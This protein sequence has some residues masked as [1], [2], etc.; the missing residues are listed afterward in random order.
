[1]ALNPALRGVKSLWDAGRLAIVRGV[2][3]PEPS[4]SH[5]RSMAV[6]QSADPVGASGPGWI[7]RWLDLTGSGA[8]RAV[9]I[10]AVLPPVLRGDK[11]AAASITAATVTLPG[12][13]MLQGGYAALTA[14]GPDRAG[15]A[16]QVTAAGADLLGVKADLDRLAGRPG[17]PAGPG[18][19]SLS[20]Q[21]QVVSSLIRAGAPT[22]VYQVSLPGFD[23]HAAQKAVHEALLADL[24][25]ALTSFFSSLA[26]SRA[27]DGVV[28]MAYSEFGRRVSENASGGTDH[29]TAAPVLVAGPRVKGGLYGE[30]PSLTNLD[31]GNL[32]YTVDFRS[33]YATMLAGVIGVEPR[34]ILG[35]RFAPLPLI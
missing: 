28:V 5:F 21:L 1:M 27:G 22:R 9:S 34:S 10:G 17:G 19:G 24:D 3:Y 14:P 2:G 20:G 6:W 29:G 35:A 13:R 23:T 33:V 4:L 15:L 7:G 31:D 25:Q 30:E 16:G 8:M 11:T 12:D 18:S 26:G 32:R